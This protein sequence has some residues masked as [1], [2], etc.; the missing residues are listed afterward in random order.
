MLQKFYGG[1]LRMKKV[2]GVDAMH[3]IDVMA[4]IGKRMRESIY[5][6]SIASEAVGWV[7]RRQVK[8]IQRSGH[9]RLTDRI[10]SSICRAA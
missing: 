6:N 5:L 9:A 7:E 1:I 8:E 4:F 3:N 10:T 2:V